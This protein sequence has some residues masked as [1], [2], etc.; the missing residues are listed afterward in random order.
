MA[1]GKACGN[2][3]HH[4]REM[5]RPASGQSR[6]VELTLT[7]DEF[8]Q[9]D[10]VG[11][12]PL[13]TQGGCCRFREPNLC[14]QW[15]AG[16]ILR[17]EQAALILQSSSRLPAGLLS[18]RRSVTCASPLSD[19]VTETTFRIDGHAARRFDEGGYH[20]QGLVDYR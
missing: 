17:G 1:L 19:F 7:Q 11:L 12:L 10:E 20:G 9:L 2:L 4:R 16:S 18:P 3:S 14:G 6:A 8:R 5:P 13:S 15:I